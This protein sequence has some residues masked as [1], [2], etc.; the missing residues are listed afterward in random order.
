MALKNR[1][2]TL[3]LNIGIA[4]IISVISNGC[5][6]DR[7]TNASQYFTIDGHLIPDTL[8][9][10]FQRELPMSLKFYIEVS[11]SMNGFFRANRPTDF[12]SDVWNVLSAFS[13]LAPQVTILTND[14]S[15]GETLQLETFRTSMN[16]GTFVSS[17]STKVPLMLQTIID[18]LNTDNGE[19]AVLI[20]DMKYSPVGSAAPEVLMSQY[21]TD[22]SH[23]LGRFGKAISIIC[24]TSDYLDKSGKEVTNRSPYYFVILGNQENVAE[25]RNYISLLLKKKGHFVDNIE[26]GFIYG[27]PEYSFGIPRKCNQLN[28]EPTFLAYEEPDDI[29]TCIIKLKIPLENYR[30]MM[31]DEDVFREAFQ[32]KTTYGSKLE[33][34]NISI[35]T[36]DVK[37][38]AKDLIREATAI[39][40]LKISNM[41]TDS[42]VVK[43]NL[44]LPVTDYTTMNEFFKDANDEND[45][46]KSFS[47]LDFLKGIFQGGITTHDM[48]PNYILITREE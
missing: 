25:L 2:S 31:A 42:E 29:D 45:P 23:I 17:S 30:W 38:A 37:G 11:G 27:H 8:T 35:E 46:T 34:G 28:N 33:I 1:I 9:R 15:Q 16:T 47:V 12:K 36:K 3:C 19:A 40:D 43:W 4:L 24:A 41:P 22:I 39:V 7:N 13:G 20:S 14:G 5:G 10:Q 18:N 6:H 48:K 26:S 44:E 21:S 32:V